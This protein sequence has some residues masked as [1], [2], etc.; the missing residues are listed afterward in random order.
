[1]HNNPLANLGA[2]SSMYAVSFLITLIFAALLLQ[3]GSPIFYVSILMFIF[4]VSSYVFSGFV[5]STM[6]LGEFQRGNGDAAPGLV[7]L[8]LSSGIIASG[9]FVTLAGTFFAEGTDALATFWGWL[10]GV[11]LM[12]I[13]FSAGIARSSTR[14]LPELISSHSKS[15]RL[16]FSLALAVLAS[17]A[18]LAITQLVFLGQVGEQFLGIPKSA[19]I[20]GTALALGICLIISGLQGVTLLRAIGFPVMFLIFMSPIIW[21]AINISGI[22]IPQLAFG[23]GALQPVADINQE[24]V[25]AGLANSEDIFSFTQDGAGLDRFNYLA[26]LICIGC[27]IASMPHLLQHFRMMETGRAARRS[28]FLAFGLVFL[29]LSA[30]PA[31]TAFVQV[32]LYTSI[33]GLQIAN[34]ETDA[35]WLFGLSGAGSLPLIELCGALIQNVEQAVAACGGNQEYFIS[36]SDI[37]IN[38]ELLTLSQGILHQLP[39]LLTL[40]LAAG[41]M[42]AIMTTLDGLVFSMS[43]SISNDGYQRFFRPQSPKSVRLFMIR[44]FIILVLVALTLSVLYFEPDPKLTFEMSMAFTAA[45]LFPALFIQIWLPKTSERTRFY[46]LIASAAFCGIGL[47]SL[48]F[49]PDLALGSGDEMNFALPILTEQVSNYG[50][51]FLGILVSFIV[52]AIAYLFEKPKT[53]SITDET[54]NAAT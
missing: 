37:S 51:G 27:A 12:T 22:P 26:T 9:A 48:N 38:P 49:G 14:T 23:T 40:V 33:L 2:L 21:M 8:A 11:A 31:V 35:A 3:I 20:Q 30:V 41:A 29:F 13:L 4:V 43:M 25:A 28:G 15:G 5:A 44:F 36:V 17:G 39:E 52:V 6:S 54:T 7:S 10:L 32:D 1:M 46:A 18:L 24:I 42:L 47:W 34:L 53:N 16:Q 50:V 19:I 45:T